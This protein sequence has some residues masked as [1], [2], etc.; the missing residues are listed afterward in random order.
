MKYS[1]TRTSFQSIHQAAWE[2]ISSF[3]CPLQPL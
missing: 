3:W 2:A 1:D